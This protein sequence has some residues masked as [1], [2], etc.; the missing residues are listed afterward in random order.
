MPGVHV[1]ARHPS[2]SFDEFIASRPDEESWE[3]I[4]GRFVM[5]AQ[6]TI[7]HQIIAWNLQ[8]LLNEALARSGASRIAVQNPMIDLGS[9]VAETKYVPDVGVLDLADIEPGRHTTKTCYLAAEIVS[10]SDKRAPTAGGKSKIET[11]LE[12]YRALSS[13]EAILVVEQ[14]RPELRLFIRRPGGWAEERFSLLE[15]EIALPDVGLRCGLSEVYARTSAM[16]HF[17]DRDA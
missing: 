10:P 9:S 15:S 8:R 6:P 4:G 3:L 13:C 14:D 2:A 16:K 17:E 12:G 1:S 11:K 5:Q 7:N